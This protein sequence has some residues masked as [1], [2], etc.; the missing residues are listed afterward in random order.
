MFSFWNKTETWPAKGLTILGL[1]T[2][3][4]FGESFQSVFRRRWKGKERERGKRRR[5][6]RGRRSGRRR[7]L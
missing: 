4:P 1:E 6:R 3:F 7:N 2:T 5:R